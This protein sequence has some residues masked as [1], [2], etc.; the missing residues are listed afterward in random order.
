MFMFSFSGTLN[1]KEFA[2][3]TVGLVVLFLMAAAGCTAI[4]TYA[5][6]HDRPF[7]KLCAGFCSLLMI[8]LSIAVVCRQTAILARRLRDIGW[9]SDLAVVVTALYIVAF[10]MVVG[11]SLQLIAS[12]FLILISLGYLSFFFIPSGKADT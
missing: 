11:T 2:L 5:L 8:G 4:E 3:Q 9:N 6:G 12:I 1:R 10:I 7:W